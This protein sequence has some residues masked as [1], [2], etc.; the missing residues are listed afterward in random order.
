MLPAERVGTR[1]ANETISTTDPWCSTR[2]TNQD[3]SGPGHAAND[4]A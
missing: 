2:H 3:R 1:V 4:R